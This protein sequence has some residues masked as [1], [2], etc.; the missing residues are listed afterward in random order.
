MDKESN[1][2]LG[3][4]PGS[5]LV[6]ALILAVG[7]LIFR[8]EPLQ[9]VRPPA[10]EPRVD[11][12]LAGQ[13]IDA[14][15]WQDPFGA[16]ARAREEAAKKSD[17]N[18]MAPEEARRSLLRQDVEDKA[19][20]G[21]SVEVLAVMLSSGPYA[22]AVESRRRTRYA[23]L[24]GLNAGGF[25]P[26]DTEHLGYVVPPRPLHG[27]APG[28]AGSAVTGT[29]SDCGAPRTA[30]R[31]PAPC[32]LAELPKVV[33]YEWF[34]TAAD[35]RPGRGPMP[36]RAVL[37]LW[38]N[39]ADFLRQPLAAWRT[40]VQSM[41]LQ[42]VGWRVIGPAGSDGLKAMVEEAGATEYKAEPLSQAGFRF[43]ASGATVPDGQL[44]KVLPEAVDDP[45][46]PAARDNRWASLAVFFADR[47]V[48]L[49]RTI[50]DD[51]RLARSLIRELGLRGL[52]AA[53]AEGDGPGAAVQSSN[54][55][56]RQQG[57]RT[58]PSPIAVVAEW[59]TLYG[60]SLRR[61]FAA[62]PDAAGF[63]VSRFNYMRG[64]DGQLP[65]PDGA[66][67]TTGTDPKSRSKG[68]E[69]RD[70]RLDDGS[71]VEIAEGQS[72][73]DYLRRLAERMRTRDRELRA[74]RAD[75]L[76]L[77]AIG[78]LGN[79]VYDKLLVLQALQPEFPDAIFFTTDLDAR[80]LH[81]REQSWTRNLIVV[82][83]FGL[84]LRDRLQ[85]GTP[86][87]RDSYQ[88]STF[89]STRLALDDTQILINDALRKAPPSV[90]D[91]FAVVAGDPGTA[92]L[93]TVAACKTLR[94][95]DDNAAAAETAVTHQEACVDNSLKQIAS[96]P[97][98]VVGSFLPGHPL[99]RE[100]LKRWSDELQRA[101]PSAG[102]ASAVVVRQKHIDDWLATPRVFEIGR[103]TP[104]DF[105]RRTGASCRG[106]DPLVMCPDIQPDGTQPYP[107]PG[108]LSLF[109]VFSLV[110]VA[111]WL[112]P[113]VTARSLRRRWLFYVARTRRRGRST[114]LRWAALLGAA[115]LLQIGL[116]VALA[117]AWHPVAAW[118]TSDGKPLLFTEG[119]S[120]WPTEG[121][122]VFTLLLCIYLVFAAWTALARNLD[123]ITLAFG[124]SA[125]RRELVEQ[126]RAAE[127]DLRWWQRLAHMFSLRFM[128][129]GRRARLLTL[130]SKDRGTAG[131]TLGAMA[132]WQ[133]H[134]VQ[135]WLPARLTRTLACVLLVAVLSE[136]LNQA[137]G[138]RRLI[139]Q[140]GAL[141]YWVHQVLHVGT[142]AAAYFL[143]FFVV[144]ATVFCVGFVRGLRRHAAN[145]PEPTLALFERRF[146]LPRCCLDAWID[147]RFI[148]RRTACVTR[149]IYLPFVVLSLLLVSRSR[150]FD[151]WTM[152]IGGIVIAGLGAV[153]MLG[154]AVVLRT[155]AER[156]RGEAL[157]MAQNL[158]MR[159][160]GLPQAAPSAPRPASVV[161]PAGSGT[162]AQAPL[163]PGG[164]QPTLQ[165]V[166]LLIRHI[167]DLREGA[168]A[169]FSQQPLLKA[170]VLPFATLGGTSLLDY[171]SLARL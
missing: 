12:R 92:R 145:W 20:R 82:S 58:A 123:A 43:Y 74:S 21:Q 144:D 154:C 128:R 27:Q 33:P 159:L 94:P 73:F 149:L 71:F 153:I 6:V 16:I 70:S 39:S 116:P 161:T 87:F 29:A 10:N 2:G 95:E 59:D 11:I 81:P 15:L 30:D 60:R 24:S 34:E 158:L 19:R 164:S 89:L 134:V 76:G 131:M 169:P 147:L 78:V 142:L 45:R 137:F 66:S 38:I 140:R 98:P 79:D 117:H 68:R 64:L 88:T 111:I 51:S 139:P 160:S 151:D 122:R 114:R 49:V 72:Q 163:P 37:V 107:D 41:A 4:M 54:A 126:Q 93:H 165:Q 129:P 23:V 102:T 3:G 14:R 48:D 57:S 80:F 141:S 32:M 152:P 148:A 67:G 61:E 36:G 40:L 5:G 86:P 55:A 112:P 109:V 28:V 150:F 171:L 108:R 162:V 146:G 101:A 26:L 75:G 100:R 22:D 170:I 155:A 84:R 110:G 99:A 130:G 62:R 121:L 103:T 31:T 77:Q 35:V 1:T 119:I 133:R 124:L 47:K 132:F 168:F 13:D 56:C 104:F 83:N 113:L 106:S 105:G 138:E 44:L 7:A 69:T 25:A 125:T 85:A 90:E 118:M 53:K 9:G 17:P 63:C 96:A 166:E 157:R 42:N 136:L 115:L 120:L 8:D 52:H 156:S 46:L 97:T 143:T 91:A 135:N 167:Q 65:D 18:W 50:G 127:A